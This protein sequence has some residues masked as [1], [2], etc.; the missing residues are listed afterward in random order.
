M[1]FFRERHEELSGAEYYSNY[2]A[3]DTT[4]IFLNYNHAVVGHE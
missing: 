1:G 3:K 2:Q 4:A